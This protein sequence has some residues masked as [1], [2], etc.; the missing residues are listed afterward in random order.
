MPV[1]TQLLKFMLFKARAFDSDQKHRTGPKPA[2]KTWG[3]THV[4]PGFIAFGAIIVRPA[5]MY[6]FN[7]NL[8][9]SPDR[10]DFSFRRTS[11]LKRVAPSHRS[12]TPKIS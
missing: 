11:V 9:I 2:G 10:R 1:F 5:L 4:T 8:L 7:L 6:K 3:V 12:T